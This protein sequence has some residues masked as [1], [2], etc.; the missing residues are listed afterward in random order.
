MTLN[1]LY[2]ANYDFTRATII[3]IKTS[4]NRETTMTMREALEKYADNEVWVFK[5]NWIELFDK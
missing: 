1:E 2:Q 4:I 3:T 5:G